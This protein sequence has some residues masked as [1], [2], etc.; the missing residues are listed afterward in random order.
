MINFL[1]ETFW[2]QANIE[3]NWTSYKNMKCS[4]FVDPIAF[5]RC[6]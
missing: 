5:L 6:Q 4:R 1:I 2:G 3:K